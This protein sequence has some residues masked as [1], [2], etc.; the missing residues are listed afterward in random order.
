MQRFFAIAALALL[1][2]C[3]AKPAIDADLTT[4]CHYK[5]LGIPAHALHNKRHAHRRRY[6][7]YCRDTNGHFVYVGVINHK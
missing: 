7:Q 1:V 3:A 6:A 2:D 4:D 5:R